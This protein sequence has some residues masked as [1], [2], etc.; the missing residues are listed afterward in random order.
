[1]IRENRGFNLIELMI[2]ILVAS[3]IVAGLYSLMTSSVVNFGISKGSAVAGASARRVDSTF[4]DLLFQTGFMNYNR[5]RTYA[6]FHQRNNT[7]ALFSGWGEN[8]VIRVQQDTNTDSNGSDMLKIRFFGSSVED[9]THNGSGGGNADGY[10]FDCQG[11][12]VPNT[13]EMELIFYV[14]TNGNSKGLICRQMVIGSN[15]ASDVVIDPN[16]IHMR[17]QVGTSIG[18]AVGQA[19]A[20]SAFYRVEGNALKAISGSSSVVPDWKDI[21]LLRY[22][23]VLSVPAGQ[24]LVKRGAEFPLFPDDTGT[25]KYTVLSTAA[26]A[27]NVHRVIN[28]SVQIINKL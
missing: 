17:V 28:G 25:P 2:S 8:Q 27:N 7:N 5:V 3:I 15:T 11:Q 16:V 9:N 4:N 10:V 26:D 19:G 13:D 18:G 20:Q 23:L 6:Y 14:R 12:P 22:A 1:M 24:K 21:N